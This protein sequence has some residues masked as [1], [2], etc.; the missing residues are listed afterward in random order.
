MR[1]RGIDCESNGG[2]QAD[3]GIEAPEGGKRGRTTKDPG[4]N[5]S[6]DAPKGLKVSVEENER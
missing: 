1:L 4:E 5:A 2:R 6:K 3:V